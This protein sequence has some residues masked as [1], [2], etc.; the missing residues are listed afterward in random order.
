MRALAKQGPRAL[1]PFDPGWKSELER[2]IL[3]VFEMMAGTGWNSTRRT[4]ASHMEN[5]R[6]WSAWPA[7]SA[8]WL[9]SVVRKLQR[10]SLLL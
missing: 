6:P 9:R 5:K 4:R 1:V 2:A 8:E 7:L 3:E 10:P